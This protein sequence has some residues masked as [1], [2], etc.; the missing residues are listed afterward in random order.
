MIK[1]VKLSAN[2]IPAARPSAAFTILKEMIFIKNNVAAPST[3]MIVRNNPANKAIT[4]I[5]RPDK[6]LKSKKSF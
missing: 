2:I 4:I 5:S 3:F 1:L 6:K